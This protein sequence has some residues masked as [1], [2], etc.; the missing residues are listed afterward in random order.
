MNTVAWIL[1][2]AFAIMLLINLRVFLFQRTIRKVH[3]KTGIPQ[4]AFDAA[5]PSLYLPM[6]FVSL[7]RYG[8]AV[9]LFFFD[10][11]A[12][13]ICL[14]ADY[15]LKILYPEQSDYKNMQKARK[16][17]AS[18][19]ANASKEQEENLSAIDAVLKEII[20]EEYENNR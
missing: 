7:L 12:A 15:L 1:V 11:K 3:M 5:Y 14:V 20:Y 13:I 18:K 4:R 6:Y 16:T 19:K 9:A 17:I 10:W 8:L 2:A